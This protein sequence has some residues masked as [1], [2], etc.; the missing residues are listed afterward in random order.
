MAKHTSLTRKFKRRSPGEM[1][2]VR[3][4]IMEELAAFRP[5]NL[6]QLY[7]RLVVAGAVPKTQND[8]QKLSKMTTKMRRSGRL[9]W[10]WLVDNSRWVRKPASYVSVEAALV[11]LVEGYRRDLWAD[12]PIYVEVW[13]ESDALAGVLYAI[14]AAYDVPLFAG[15]G[16]AGATYVHDAGVE[17][18]SIAKPIH[19]LYIGDW[20]PSGEC[21]ENSIEAALREDALDADITFTRLAVTE[22]Q[23]AAWNL[24]G[25]PPKAGDPRTKGWKGKEAVEAE[26]IPPAALQDMLRLAIERLMDPVILVDTRRQERE[27][28]ER[29]RRLVSGKKS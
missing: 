23:I 28:R 20:D 21:I 12:Q 29:L 7:Y 25:K 1:E 4:L 6:R 27:D 26:A 15:H 5:M 24:P 17:L 18:R 9:P 14:T 11:E 13:V 2:A 3:V 8:Y 22:Q 16:F 10:E 19:I